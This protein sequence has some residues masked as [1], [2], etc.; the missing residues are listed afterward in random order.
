M[1]H[2]NENGSITTSCFKG[3]HQITYQCN[4][5]T[6]TEMVNL[7]EDQT[8]T[9][10][11]DN[12]QTGTEFLE[13]NDRNFF[14]ISPNPTN[15]YLNVEMVNALPTTVVLYNTLGAKV[16][17]QL[18]VDTINTI[19]VDHLHGVYFLELQNEKTKVFPRIVIE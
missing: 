11:C 17:E 19:P 4:G 16:L 8:I 18:L 7:K 9:I 14:T 5:E 13:E 12:L 2:A 15:D 1:V 6:I 10:V 3:L